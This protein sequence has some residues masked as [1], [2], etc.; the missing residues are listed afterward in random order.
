MHIHTNFYST[1]M[2]HSIRHIYFTVRYDLIIDDVA[3]THVLDLFFVFAPLHYDDSDFACTPHVS[4]ALSRWT[5]QDSAG[6]SPL[7]PLH[8]LA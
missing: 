3:T 5:D 1:H 8:G 7:H 6:D 2:M 4:V